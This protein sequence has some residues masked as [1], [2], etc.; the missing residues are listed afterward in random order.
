MICQD[1]A[2]PPEKKNLNTVAGIIILSGLQYHLRADGNVRFIPVPTVQTRLITQNFI[3]TIHFLDIW[4]RLPIEAFISP[5]H[6]V[7][8]I[9]C[10]SK[11]V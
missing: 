6:P 1:D 2:H 8:G 10:K 9:T 4:C 5:A 11:Q 7:A 3:E